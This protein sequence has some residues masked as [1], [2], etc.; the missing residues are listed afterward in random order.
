V[1]S[2]FLRR[3]RIAMPAYGESVSDEEISAIRSWIFEMR[4]GAGQ[5]RR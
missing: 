4:G 5:A 2:F 1:V 3:Q